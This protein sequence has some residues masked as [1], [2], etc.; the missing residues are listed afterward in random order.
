MKKLSVLAISLSLF[1]TFSANAELKFQEIRTASNNVLVVYYK[2]DVIKPDEVKTDDPNLWKLNGQPVTAINKF[3]TEADNCDHHIYLHVPVLVN[4]TSYKLETP[5]GEHS[6][7]FDDTK[8]FCE[9]IKTNQGAY[10]ALSKIRYANFAVWL[11]DG[12]VKKIEGALPAYTVFQVSDNKVIT[13]GTLDEI[14]Q[15]ASSGDFVYRIDLSAVPEGGPYKISVKGYGCSYPFGVGGDFSR[16]L[17]HISFRSLYHQRCGCPIIEPY[18]WNIKMKP[19]HTVIYK[20]NAPIGE[21]NLRVQGTEPTFIAYGGYHDAGDA[22]RR[23]YHMDVP[24][25]LLTTYEAFRDLFTDDQYNIPD[26][27]DANYN[28]IGKGNKIPDIIDEAEWGTIFWEYMQEEDGQIHW[29]TETLRYSPFTT[30]DKEDKLFG[31]EV[32]DPRSASFGA[33]IFMHLARIIKPYNPKRSEELFKHA[34]LAM[35]AAGESPVPTHK[36]YY[37]VQKYL[38]TGDEEAHKIIKELADS[39]AG[40]ADTYNAAPEQFAGNRFGGGRRGGFG[41][42]MGGGA[43]GGA[44]LA[45]FFFSYIIEKD[46]PTDP[47]VVEKFKAALKAAADKQIGYLEANAYPVGTPTNLSWWGSNVAQGQYAFPCLLYW[48]LTKEQ[49][50]IDAASQ[51]MDYAMGLNP[52]GKCFMTGI[53]FNRVHNPHDRESAYTKEMGWGPRP[54]I[55]IF[56]PGLRQRNNDTIPNVSTLSRER[57]FVDHLDTYQWTEFTIYQSLCFPSAV[58]PVLAQGGKYDASKDP[59]AVK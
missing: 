28:I 19:C 41:G 23:T 22:D 47:A 38:L 57:I 14:G 50:Y 26:I 8:I 11:G 54:G 37:A 21:A 4:G 13:K 6:F 33:G 55:L 5:H 30:Y 7:I 53:G 25:T 32:T 52:M 35:K 18:A 42:A 1:F 9:S 10:S 2:S 27:F 31:T 24:A 12:G 40:Y 16:R 39:A 46:R 43:S 3:I 17:A 58:Y 59:F 36:L 49:K 34:E 44:W 20:T 15:D 29:G 48:S 51:L 45:S 56:G